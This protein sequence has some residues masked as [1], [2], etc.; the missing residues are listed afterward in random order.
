MSQ[1]ALEKTI[2]IVVDIL[3]S[4]NRAHLV[5]LSPSACFVT[6]QS[7]ML[8]LELAQL[9]DEVGTTTALGQSDFDLIYDSLKDF[10]TIWHNCGKCFSVLFT[11][12]ENVEDVVE[13]WRI[14]LTL[15]L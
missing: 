11:R 8:Y 13:C 1:L 10:A 7:A 15:R 12:Y 3:R 6:F 5:E 2:Q 4:L 14:V 9:A